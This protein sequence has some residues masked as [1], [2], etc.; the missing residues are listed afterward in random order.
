[1]VCANYD[2]Q[3]I[4]FSAERNNEFHYSF[5]NYDGLID[6]MQFCH[7]AIMN[8]VKWQKLIGNYLGTIIWD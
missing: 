5:N 1:M 4:T 3:T 6:E 8:I 7:A 2:R